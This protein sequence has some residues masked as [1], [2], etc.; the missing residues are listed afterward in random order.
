[1]KL[2]H[3]EVAG[4]A[5]SLPPNVGVLLQIHVDVYNPNSYDIAVRAVRGQ[6]VLAGKYVVPVNFTAQGDGVWLNS[7]TTSRVVVPVE[8]P[9]TTSLAVLS[10]TTFTAV[11][12]YHFTGKADVTATRSLKLE[13]DDYS[14]SEDGQ[15]SRDQIQAGLHVG[16]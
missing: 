15:I 4:L 5:V 11:V 10:G 2:N 6:V 16:R 13:K 8:V 1:M 9:L 7:D 3:A 12:P 14:V